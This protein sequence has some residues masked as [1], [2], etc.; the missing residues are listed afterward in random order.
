MAKN[1]KVGNLEIEA[2]DNSTVIRMVFSPEEISIIMRL[3]DIGFRHAAQEAGV[4]ILT[5]AGNLKSALD[6]LQAEFEKLTEE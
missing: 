4:G 5:E 1:V 3:T 6:K 2:G